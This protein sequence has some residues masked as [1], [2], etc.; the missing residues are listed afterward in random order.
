MSSIQDN[1]SKAYVFWIAMLMFGLPLLSSF[2][3]IIYTP[4]SGVRVLIPYILVSVI[5]GLIFLTKHPQF[6]H[7]KEDAIR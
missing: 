4:G 1:L 7:G 5:I 6:R 3:P 2:Y